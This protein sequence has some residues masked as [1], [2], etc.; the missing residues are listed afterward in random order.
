[1]TLPIA[2]SSEKM[3]EFDELMA[4]HSALGERISIL[5]QRMKTLGDFDMGIFSEIERCNDR[6][7]EI[8]STVRGWSLL[9]ADEDRDDRE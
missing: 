1:M 3:P 7:L 6:M 8:I 2:I 5:T 4:E 9:A